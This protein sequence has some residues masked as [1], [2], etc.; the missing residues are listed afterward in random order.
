MENLYSALTDPRLEN[1]WVGGEETN[2]I[3]EIGVIAAQ[4]LAGTTKEKSRTFL[5]C[6]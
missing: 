5:L 3:R 1:S 6:M 2:A 4:G